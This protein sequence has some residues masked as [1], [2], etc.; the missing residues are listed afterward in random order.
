MRRGRAFEDPWREP[1]REYRSEVRLV[2]GCEQRS[3]WLP[4]GMVIPG[5]SHETVGGLPNKDDGRAGHS[6]DPT[7]T[8]SVPSPGPGTVMPTVPGSSNEV[9][10]APRRGFLNSPLGL[11]SALFRRS[12]S[13]SARG[14]RR[15][16]R[17]QSGELDQCGL[18]R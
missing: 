5:I 7:V 4:T 10:I 2:D 12:P 6:S 17:D 11:D 13:L 1:D 9:V 3:G 14:D 15:G 16:W 8:F 18:H